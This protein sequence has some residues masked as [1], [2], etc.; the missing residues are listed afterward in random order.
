MN[1]L[2]K[3]YFMNMLNQLAV[4]LAALEKMED[5]AGIVA[6]FEEDREKA[7]SYFT[8]AERLYKKDA[9]PKAFVLLDSAFAISK[10]IDYADQIARVDA[11]YYQIQ[12]LSQ[13]GSR[14]INEQADA[15]LRDLPEGGKY[16]GVFL[17]V[18][19]LAYEGNFYRALTAIPNTL[20]EAQ[21]LQC[22]TAILIEACKAREKISWK[23]FLE[24]RWIYTWN[25]SLFTLIIYRI[26]EKL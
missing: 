18:A 17:R 14:E 16:D 23:Y 24:D 13:I 12:V 7:L 8:M 26:N 10:R 5:A 4:N 11:R 25:G 21:D 6:K 3:V 1:M 19:G 20:T 9:N 2:E 22:R 15:I